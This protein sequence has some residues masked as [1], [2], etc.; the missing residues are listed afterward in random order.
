MHEKIDRWKQRLQRARQVAIC[1]LTPHNPTNFCRNSWP[2][3]ASLTH[4]R[5]KPVHFKAGSPRRVLLWEPHCR[6]GPFS[7]ASTAEPVHDKAGSWVPRRARPSRGGPLCSQAGPSR[8]RERGVPPH[9]SIRCPANSAKMRRSMPDSGLGLSP[10]SDESREKLL[11][12]SISLGSSVQLPEEMPESH[13]WWVNSWSDRLRFVGGVPRE[14]KML[15]G[16]LPRVR[17]HQVCKY[18]KQN[19]RFF[20]EGWKEA[21]LPASGFISVYFGLF[22]GLL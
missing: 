19:V 4:M 12:C 17:Y 6:G 1:P 7:S 22:R 10:F 14:Q 5:A 20:S 11:S 9:A 13:D 2:R 15:K 21:A 18:T 3:R 16:H 8:S